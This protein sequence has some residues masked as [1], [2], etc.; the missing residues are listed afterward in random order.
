MKERGEWWTGEIHTHIFLITFTSSL[1]ERI[2]KRL[3]KYSYGS[4]TDYLWWKKNDWKIAKKNLFHEKEK[5]KSYKVNVL[6]L[7]YEGLFMFSNF[8]TI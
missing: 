2:M 6:L 8:H 4:K 3:N 7:T 5:Q 1:V